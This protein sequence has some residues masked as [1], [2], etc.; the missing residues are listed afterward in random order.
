MAATPE[1]QAVID[2]DASADTPAVLKIKAALEAPTEFAFKNTP[3]KDV[4]EQL[5]SRHKIEIQF[6]PAGLKDAGVEEVEPITKTAKGISLS[7]ALRLLLD[8]LQL[9]HVIHNEV[10]LIT[11]TTKSESD[12]FMATK[13]YSV[14]D[15]VLVRNENGE[16]ETDFQ[17][18]VDLIIN[19]VESK[20][21][22]DN[23]GNGT[24]APFQIENRC[25]LV[26]S[27]TQDVHE[28]IIALLGAL[29]RCTNG[30]A[31]RG[32]EFELPKRP[33]SKAPTYY[34]VPVAE[35]RPTAAKPVG[36]MP[37]GGAFGF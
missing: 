10:L 9:R 32:K 34:V 26:V 19:T 14:K 31:R 24:I 30:D 6:D 35:P 21:W 5:K 11:S 36:L 25:L 15:L 23:G 8:E 3:L 18:L 13:I 4:I 1:S 20:C 22:A 29:R 27:Q 28:Q 7:S 17:S 33:R 12:E 2:A 37:S 16:I